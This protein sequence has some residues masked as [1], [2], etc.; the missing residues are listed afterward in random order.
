MVAVLL[1]DEP[2]IRVPVIDDVI[3]AARRSAATVLRASYRDR[4]GHP[5]V[6]KESCLAQVDSLRPH[7]NTQRWLEGFGPIEMV[8]FPFDA[9]RD[10]DVAAD[11]DTLEF[12]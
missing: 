9:P 10:V 1:A 3:T 12:A 11:L 4:P 7:T 8:D 6:L 2:G 5:V